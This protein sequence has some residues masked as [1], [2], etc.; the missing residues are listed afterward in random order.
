MDSAEEVRARPSGG[1]ARY[2][3]ALGTALL[4][5]ILRGLFTPWL[6]P[7]NPYHT[8]W[9]AVV[10]AAWYFG[11]GP[12]ILTTLVSATGVWYWFLPPG[13]TFLVNDP[14]EQI[15]GTTGFLVMSGFIIA[16]GDANRRSKERSAIEIRQRTATEKRLRARETELEALHSALAD[17][18]EERTA[19]LNAAIAGLRQL[20]ARL[21]QAQDD[22]RRRLARELHDSVGQLLA[23]INMNLEIMRGANLTPEA[24]AAVDE[25]AALVDQISSE[26]RTMSH[27]LHP[28][29][30]D[31]VGLASALQW[32][33][34]GFSARSKISVNLEIAGDFGRLPNDMEIAI[35]RMVQ[36]CLT[37]VHRHSESDSGEVRL[38]RDA[39]R[40][41]IEVQDKGKGIPL[42][43]QRALNSSQQAGVGFRGMRE[44]IQQLGG[45]LEIRSDEH[46]TSIKATMPIRKPA[47]AFEREVA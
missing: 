36:E 45:R 34:D 23:A 41:V 9:A 20:S 10:L 1:V 26:I 13:H 18:V 29:L 7:H 42:E 25:N 4:A 32:Y 38:K 11:L 3:F 30:L 2:G 22:E 43:K 8:V 16:L 35:F 46:G 39:E 12:A 19:E 44:R 14:K 47:A 21:L 37:N 15:V 33:I 5:L 40:V 17:R 28:P 24:A 31:E 27:L 6:G